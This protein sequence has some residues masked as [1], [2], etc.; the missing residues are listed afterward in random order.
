QISAAHPDINLYGSDGHHANPEGVYLSA[1]V[2][3][4]RMF[5][6]SPE[7]AAEKL[8]FGS[9][10]QEAVLVNITKARASQL[11]RQASDTVRTMH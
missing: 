6:K 11:Q 2:L 5:G 4:A 10:G 1:C 8:S 3:Y 7:G 9:P